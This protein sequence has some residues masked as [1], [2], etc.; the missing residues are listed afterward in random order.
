[1]NITQTASLPDSPKGATP[2]PFCLAVRAHLPR[3]RP[4]GSRFLRGEGTPFRSAGGG[5]GQRYTA[6]FPRGTRFR[7]PCA[8]HP[9]HAL[10]VIAASKPSDKPGE[11]AAA[12]VG[13]VAGNVRPRQLVPA[14]QLLF[15][16]ARRRAR[17]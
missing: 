17:G 16:R 10:Y 9:P 1:T 8:F 2:P 12:A 3:L 4:G 7:Q 15:H 11:T 14:A 5:R 6:H 13:G